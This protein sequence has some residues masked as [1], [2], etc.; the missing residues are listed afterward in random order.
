MARHTRVL[1]L[2]VALII[3]AAMTSRAQIDP[4]VAD[5]VRVDSVVTFTISGGVV[6]PV[7]LTNDQPVSIVEVTLLHSSDDVVLDSISF[8]GTRLQT[9]SFPTRRKLSDT[10]LTFGAAPS[11]ELPAGS[12]LIGKLF[13]SFGPST[14]P[15]LVTFDTITVTTPTNIVYRNTLKSGNDPVYVPQFVP[16]YI[17][18]Q[19]P[20][21]SLDSLWVDDATGVPGQTF[22]TDLYLYNE[23]N[24]LD[25]TVTLDYGSDYIKIDSMVYTGTRG[26][27][28]I[29][30]LFT[31]VSSLHRLRLDLG[32]TEG[33]PLAPGAG[34]IGRMFFTVDSAAVDTSIRIDTAQGQPTL[35]TFTASAGG[36]QIIPIYHHGTVTLQVATDVGDEPPSV[37]PGHF[38]L[39]QNYPNPFNPSTYI[40]FSLPRAGHVSLDVFNI[41]GQRVRT[42]LDQAMPAG[43][44]RV[45]FDGRS[46]SGDE[47][48][49]GV[50]LYRLKTDDNVASRKMI[51]MK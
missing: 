47:L 49:T 1:I 13:F 29:E 4:G 46:S 28:A 20:P 34:P 19:D 27:T 26:A 33:A 40:E 23:R 15:Q 24:V 36:E 17:E 11:V 18:I 2:I 42:L 41:L 39:E 44:H 38:S 51:L 6:L 45:V 31:P 35:L 10:T 50:Y 8:V 9:A 22:F 21:P 48:S 3:L 25:L 43:F 5:T 7:Y 37:L 16:G 14:I 12:G 30:K 32:W